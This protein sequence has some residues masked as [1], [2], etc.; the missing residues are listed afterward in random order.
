M[1][2]LSVVVPAFEEAQRLTPSLEAIQAYLLASERWLPAEV[3]VVDDGSADTTAATARRFAG[4]DRLRFEVLSHPANRGKGAA[5]RTGFAA[6][7]G[8]AVLLSDADLAT[9]IEE[10]ERLVAAAGD[11]AVA[12]GSRA[13][14]RDLIEVPQPRYR[15][16]MGRAFNLG[17]RALALP[18]VRD[19]QCGFKLFPGTLARALA[20]VQQIDGF[21]FDV[22]LLVLARRWGW[23]VYEVPVRWRHVE[24]S[25]VAPLR[26]SSEM[27]RD[28]LG[29]A[30]RRILGRLPS[31]PQEAQGMVGGK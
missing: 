22:E 2:R 6:S 14:D 28:L 11:A 29:L 1:T 26:H 19:S 7:R 24:A 20:G 27:L 17:V 23:T 15:D 8:E 3:V 30:A 16:L 13:V 25:R 31:P 12:I 5:V 9:P 10:L 21:A 4:S 18:G